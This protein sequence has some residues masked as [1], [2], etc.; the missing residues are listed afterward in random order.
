[1]MLQK[2]SK[3]F[4]E[5][6]DKYTQLSREVETKEQQIV[7][8]MSHSVS[9]RHTLLKHIV[10][11]CVPSVYRFSSCAEALIFGCCAAAGGSALDDR[12][13]DAS[14][15]LLDQDVDVQFQRF[16][17]QEIQ[18]RNR[19]IQEIERD[20]RDLNEMFRDL[21]TLVESQQEQFDD[22]ERN[23]VEAKEQTV[24]GAQELKSVCTTFKIF[25]F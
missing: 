17:A 1:M 3:Q 9:G 11:G 21:H 5:P 4:Q 8:V 18:R 16:D 22:I 20:V 7:S 12:R 24:S 10:C 13:D 2:L 19:V 14:A 15:P 25:A 23:I 6:L